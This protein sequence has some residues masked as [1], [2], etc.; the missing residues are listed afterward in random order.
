M[1]LFFWWVKFRRFGEFLPNKPARNATKNSL[2]LNFNPQ[3]ISLELL[4]AKLRE[5]SGK[6]SEKC[7]CTTKRRQR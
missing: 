7:K 1:R 4:S 2:P 3:R 6:I 5:K